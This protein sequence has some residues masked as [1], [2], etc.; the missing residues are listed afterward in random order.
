[1]EKKSRVEDAVNLFLS[2]YNCCQSVFCAYSDIFG[3]DRETALK[4]SCSLGGGMGRMREVCGAVS[5]MAL[6]AGLACGNADPKNQA[7]KT[8][9]YEMVRKMA[10]AF[11][12]RHQSIICREIL[13]IR[14]AEKSA[15]PSERTKEYYQN[16]PC[17]R[18]VETA[19][20]II[21]ETFPEILE[22]IEV[23]DEEGNKTGICSRE[24]AHRKGLWHRVV[25][26]WMYSREDGQTW[27]YFQ[28]RAKTKK[29]FPGLYD[30]A[31]AGHMDLGE[32]HRE[33]VIRE[34]KEELGI[35]ID[36][37][38]LQYLGE[39]RESRK[40]KGLLT[41]KLNMCIFVRLI[42]PRLSLEMRLTR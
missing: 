1:M 5:G 22:V 19:A 28:K 9:N 14:A 34:T 16:R 13:G 10:D 41:G 27:L 26:C 17:A 33:A 30:L 20:Q 37:E 36:S 6:V 2:G 4:L 38:N 39:M 23:Y 12:Q 31:S 11:K 21:E 24:E 32:S 18:M 3:L 42:C 8:K 40:R 25:H 15:A 7:A 35:F 29:D